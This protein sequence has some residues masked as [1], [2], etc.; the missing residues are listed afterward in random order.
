M[1]ASGIIGTA[2]LFLLLGATAP[3]RAQE[4][5]GKETQGKSDKQDKGKGNAQARRQQQKNQERKAAPQAKR[6]EGIREVVAKHPGVEI[7]QTI[8]DM[9]QVGEATTKIQSALAALQAASESAMTAAPAPRPAAPFPEVEGVLDARVFHRLSLV[10]F[11]AWI[12]LGA[13]GLSSSNYGPQEAFLALGAHPYL[14]IFVAL[15]SV[16]TIFIIAASYSQIVELFPTGGGG[17]LVASKLLSPTVGMISGSA[18]MVDYVLTITLSVASG[19][20]ALRLPFRDRSFDAVT[21]TFGLR[22]LDDWMKGLA[23]IARVLRPGGR[24]G[25]LEFFRSESQGSRFVHGAYNRLALPVL[26]RLFTNNSQTQNR[27]GVRSFGG[28]ASGVIAGTLSPSVICADVA[29]SQ[30][31]SLP[32]WSRDSGIGSAAAYWLSRRAGSGRH[33]SPPPPRPMGRWVRSSSSI[34]IGNYRATMPGC[35][36]CG[37]WPSARC[38]SPGFPAVGM[39]TA[40]V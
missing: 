13:D 28:D 36:G 3:A 12:G 31:A 11:F 33:P 27:T 37:R 39:A 7:V 26:G 10:A 8:S 24:L 32:A 19:A 14:G 18:L 20:D 1:K 23:E 15:I 2:A 17:Y 9:I 22:N 16:I 4:D 38:P 6:D 29:S 25:V 34:S 35:A 5:K 21:V 30:S 40:T